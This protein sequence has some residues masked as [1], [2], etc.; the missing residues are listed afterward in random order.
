MRALRDEGR[1]PVFLHYTTGTFAVTEHGWF[2]LHILCYQALLHILQ[3]VST[4]LVFYI[5]P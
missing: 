4:T 2:K 1:L 3:E 5:V